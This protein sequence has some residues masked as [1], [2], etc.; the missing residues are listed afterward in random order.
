MDRNISSQSQ[1]SSCGMRLPTPVVICKRYRRL[2]QQHGA[3]VRPDRHQ[4]SL[5]GSSWRF[6]RHVTIVAPIGQLQQ[7]W[8]ILRVALSRAW[9]SP[10]HQLRHTYSQRRRP[11]IFAGPR[12]SEQPAL[13]SHTS[14]LPPLGKSDHVILDCTFSMELNTTAQRQPRQ[15]WMYEKADLEQI[16]LTRP[17]IVLTGLKSPML[18]TLTKLGQRGRRC[19][20]Q[21]STKTLRQKRVTTVDLN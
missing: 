8:E 1:F 16:N 11:W 13:L 19:S 12:P 5:R 9:T 2:R 3:S 10:M 14:A 6:Q 21:L 4:P 20:S 18:Q 7:R 17:S 15:I